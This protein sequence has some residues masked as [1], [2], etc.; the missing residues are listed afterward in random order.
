MFHSKSPIKIKKAQPEEQ[1]GLVCKN[2]SWWFYMR[3]TTQ[4]AVVVPVVVVV[5]R[6]EKD[7]VFIPWVTLSEA[8]S[9]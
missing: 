7:T 9:V 2:G 6:R 3:K 5:V 8:T 1:A 4:P